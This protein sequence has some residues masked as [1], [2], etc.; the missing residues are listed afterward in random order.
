M[1]IS[2]KSVKPE[3]KMRLPPPGL[4]KKEGKG[5]PFPSR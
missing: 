1:E 5:E 3:E 4:D 2:E